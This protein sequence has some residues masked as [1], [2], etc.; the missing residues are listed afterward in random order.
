MFFN[1]G[2]AL[3]WIGLFAAVRR[4][5]LRLVVILLFHA[6][7]MLVVVT[8]T[9]AHYYFLE[10][11]TTLD[12]STLAEWIPKFEEIVPI[13]F[14]GGIPLLAWML[15]A[16][17]LL[18]VALGPLFV[19]R[20]AER[21]R[22][23]PQ[24][25]FLAVPAEASSLGSLG[26]FLLGLGFGSLSLLTGTT[27]L[28]RA[29]FVNVVLTGIKQ[30]TTEE[31]ISDAGQRTEHPAA[32]ASL[33]ETS[34]TDKRNVVLIHLESTRAQSVTPYNED[35]NTTPFLNELAK[36]SLLVERAYVV[37]PRSSKATVTVNCGIDPPLYQGPEF[38]PGGIPAPCLAS[39]LK[40][41]GYSTVFFQSSSETMDQYG[42]VA[43][44]LG[45]EDYYPSESMD[46]E[47]FEA[48]NYISYEDDI[49]LKPSEE[50]LKEH[51]HEPFLVQ[52][53]TGT[54]HGDY[55][56]LS[57]RYGSEH[58]AQDDDQL[59]RY[60]NCLRLQDIFLENLF[61]QYKE[62]GLYENTVFVIYGD[63]GEGFG[64]HGR[65]LHGDTPWEEGL[66]VPLIIHD[67][68]RPQ[69]DERVE[70]LSNQTDIL[71]TVV[72]MLGYEVES[73][74]YPGYSL[75]RPL[76][77]DRILRFS[78]ISSRKCLASLNGDEKYIYHYDNQPEEV[79]NLSEDPLEKQNL[80]DEYSKEDLDKRREDLFQWLSSVNSKYGHASRG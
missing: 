61:D 5:S 54:G 55:R 20:T 71:P 58:L 76:P 21:W 68:K 63:H 59:N 11:G 77:E 64:E 79:F 18:Y 1:L 12:Y 35:L 40:N 32:Q 3:L 56:C 45:Y 48:T 47:G 43:E 39:L 31:G 26:L 73:G 80:A 42:V 72:E 17:A 65:F 75:L 14:Q 8:T 62:L 36:A 19:A 30:V 44:N 70:G 27:T 16:A 60:L 24:V 10:N 67:P 2:F 78:C 22:G 41:Q 57:T 37:V 46:T 29:P 66:R 33:A 49:M 53:L 4:R 25:A 74:D 7:T 34:R 6:T 15:L 50:W 52:Y 9:V 13:L 38:D 28:A 23:W 51:K 69:N